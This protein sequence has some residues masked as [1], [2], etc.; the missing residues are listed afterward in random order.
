[1]HAAVMI[2][3]TADTRTNAQINPGAHMAQTNAPLTTARVGRTDYGPEQ[4]ARLSHLCR[5]DL[6]KLRYD[7][8]GGDSPGAAFRLGAGAACAGLDVAWAG[9]RPPCQQE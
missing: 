2:D 5:H 7:W 6:A 3:Y 9:L 4:A 8:R 1:M